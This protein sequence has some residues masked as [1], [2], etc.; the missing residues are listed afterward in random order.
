MV[1]AKETKVVPHAVMSEKEAS[2]LQR[3]IILNGQN[4]DYVMPD[5]RKNAEIWQA[6]AAQGLEFL[7]EADEFERRS[8]KAN[9]PRVA[10]VAVRVEEAGNVVAT[11]QSE[12]PAATQTV[13]SEDATPHLVADELPEEFPARAALAEGGYTLRS[14]LHALGDEEL[15]AVS[16]IGP[17]TA[18]KIREALT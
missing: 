15:T 8:L 11:V 12:A 16:G 4:P 14:Q 1:E 17:A 5:G 7:K 3:E 2:A 6:R 18:A 13:A 10:E 9:T